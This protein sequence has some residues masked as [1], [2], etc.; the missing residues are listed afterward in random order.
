MMLVSK[1]LSDQDALK[2]ENERLREALQEIKELTG[3]LVK[4]V[5]LVSDMYRLAKAAPVCCAERQPCGC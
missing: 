4:P 3:L 5:S 1:A 2:A